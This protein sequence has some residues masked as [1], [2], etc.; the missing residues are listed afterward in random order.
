MQGIRCAATHMCAALSSSW[1]KASKK[2]FGHVLFACSHTDDWF[3]GKK[4]QPLFWRLP[5]G[6]FHST[7]TET[8]FCKI[9]ALRKKGVTLNSGL[10]SGIWICILMFPCTT[11]ERIDQS[12]QLLLC[13][14]SC[15]SQA[16]YFAAGLWG[17]V[18]IILSRNMHWKAKPLHTAQQERKR[19]TIRGHHCCMQREAES[20]VAEKLD[21]CC[22]LWGAGAHCVVSILLSVPMACTAPAELPANSTWIVLGQ[23]PWGWQEITESKFF[24]LNLHVTWI[25]Q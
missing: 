17:K 12:K 24:L 16:V 1:R 8:C 7:V 5:A 25:C 4:E 21:V 15:E 18:V 10:R 6:I 2:L 19:S 14:S 3:W 9:V 22:S 13:Y 11:S 20:A 23:V